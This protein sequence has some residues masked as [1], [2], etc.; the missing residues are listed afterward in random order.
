MTGID[1]SLTGID[2]GNSKFPNIIMFQ[3][4]NHLYFRIFQNIYKK[5]K[6][7]RF[8]FEYTTFFLLKNK[9]KTGKSET[10]TYFEKHQRTTVSGKEISNPFIN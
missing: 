2:N 7:Q 3:K 8:Y 1:G 9:R 4:D 10:A 5:I 6:I